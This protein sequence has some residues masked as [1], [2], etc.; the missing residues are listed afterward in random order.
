MQELFQSMANCCLSGGADG[1]D[2]QWGMCAGL[3]GHNVIHW[4]FSGHRSQAPEIELVR[5]NDAQLKEADEAI[6]VAAVALKKHP[7]GKPWVKSLIQ[8]NYY[9]V[10]WSSSCYAVTT[11]KDNVVQGGTA[12]ATTMFTQLHPGN[13]NVY[14]FDQDQDSWFQYNGSTWDQIEAPPKPT[15]IWAGIGSRDLKQN[16]KDAIRKLMDYV[17]PI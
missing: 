7:P 11:I 3:I 10:A 6:K 1:A 17:K 14:V 12:W 5:L 9:Q 15:G 8:R 2:V 4:S 16:G 13:H